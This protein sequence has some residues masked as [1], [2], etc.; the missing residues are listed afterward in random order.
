M[1]IGKSL[2]RALTSVFWPK[3][4]SDITAL[5]SNCNVC[6]KH[7]YSN[8]KQPLQSHP[9]PDYPWKVVATDLFLWDNTEFFVV[10]DYYSRHFEVVQLRDTKSKTTIQK[11]KSNFAR[12]G[13]P[14]KVV[15]DNGPQ[16]SSQEFANFSKEYDFTHATSSP[17]YPQSNG[18]AEKSVQIVKRIFKKAELDGRDPYLGILEYR[19]TP[20][21]VGYSPA[22]L[23]QNRQLRSILPT[24]ND[25]L[26]PKVRPPPLK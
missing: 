15:S 21:E 14:R 2:Q 18:L 4:S 24:L 16:Y 5:V 25:Q 8:P 10:T 12:L 13:I 23:L 7:R 26:L 22:E 20:L 19:T 1:G 3:I 17:R 11:L 9:V 6:L